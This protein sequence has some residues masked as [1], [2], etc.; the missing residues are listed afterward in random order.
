MH[1]LDYV[2]CRVGGLKCRGELFLLLLIFQESPIILTALLS[3]TPIK[4]MPAHHASNVHWKVSVTNITT[5]KRCIEANTIGFYWFPV[6]WVVFY[7]WFCVFCNKGPINTNR[8][9]GLQTRRVVKHEIEKGSHLNSVTAE[10][11]KVC[12]ICLRGSFTVAPI[13]LM[14][15]LS[16]VNSFYFYSRR[17]D[18]DDF[19]SVDI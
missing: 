12:F 18:Q 7:A 1:R 2:A 15:P 10:N 14:P 6:A 13:D 19:S 5:S 3:I 11:W 4:T 8:E 17:I 9:P 16:R